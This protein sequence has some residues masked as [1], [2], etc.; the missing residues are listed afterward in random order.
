M[1]AESILHWRRLFGARAIPLNRDIFCFDSRSVSLGINYG[2]VARRTNVYVLCI[3]YGHFRISLLFM[4]ALF[5]I[6][7]RN[8]Q[9]Y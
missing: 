8:F 2:V 9:S 1:G 5:E 4:A 6:S 3:Y 7:V